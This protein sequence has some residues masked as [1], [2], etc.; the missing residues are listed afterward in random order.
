MKLKVGG[1]HISSDC[2]PPSGDF[3]DPISDMRRSRSTLLGLGGLIHQV[4][5]VAGKS[6]PEYCDMPISHVRDVE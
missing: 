1:M 3:H 6:I 2:C 4:H 5:D